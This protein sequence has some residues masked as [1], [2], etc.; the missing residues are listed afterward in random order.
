[1]SRKALLPVALAVVTLGAASCGGEEVSGESAALGK[2]GASAPAVQTLT[3]AADATYPPNEFLAPDGHT[4][5]GMSAD[6]VK[7]LANEMGV[8]VK[9]VNA[10]FDSILPGLAAGKYDVGFSSFTDTKEREKTVDFVTY[11]SAGTSFFVRTQ[12]GPAIEGLSDLCGRTIAVS[13]GTIQADDAAAQDKKCRADGRPG[14]RVLVLPDQPAANLALASGRADVSMT[15]SPVAAYQ[16][17]Q[18]G[19]RLKLVGR[20]YGTAPYG[21]ALPKDSGMANDIKRALTELMRDGTYDSILRKWGV[22]VGAI[23][24]PTINGAVD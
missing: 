13:K 21:I 19:G 15:D 16:V 7:A 24:E 23:D 9:L 11:Y 14:V 20:P 1:M 2:G 22:H 12:D 18:S 17:K 8:R 10:T 3:V 5:V 4:I 6:L